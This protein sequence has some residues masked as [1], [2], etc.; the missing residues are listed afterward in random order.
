M[1]TGRRRIS[2]LSVWGEDDGFDG[3]FEVD[4]V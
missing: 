3:S 2:L 1:R 4:V